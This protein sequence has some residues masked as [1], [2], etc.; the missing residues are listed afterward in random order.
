MVA[1]SNFTFV[2]LCGIL[3][4]VFALQ[5]LQVYWVLYVSLTAFIFFSYYEEK[6]L[7]WMY[8]NLI[9]QKPIDYQAIPRVDHDKKRGM[10]YP[11][12]MP[13]TWYHFVDSSELTVGKVME[14]RAL[15]RTFVLW[16]ATDGTPV[17]QDAYCVHLGA[18]LGVG[19]KVVDNCIECPFH[20]WK[21]NK[22]GTVAEIP[23]NKEP[24]N[25]PTHVKQ[26]TYPCVDWCGWVCVWYHVDDKDPE[27][28]MPEYVPKELKDGDWMPHM[29]WDIGLQT[30][31]CIDW[32]DQVGDHAHFHTLHDEFLIPWT[33]L[34]L[35]A[36][37]LYFFPIA[38]C[39]RLTT[40]MGDDKEWVK[41]V[42]ETGWGAT[43]KHLVFFND[44]AGITW[45]G[46]PIEATMSHTTEMY[47]GP[48][49]IVFHIPFTI[50]IVK[51]FVSNLPVETG[52]IMRVRTWVD[53]RVKHSFIKQCIAWVLT[54]IGA[55]QL[56]CDIQILNNKIRLRK[57]TIQP[58]D[59]PYNRMTAWLKNFM[60]E[61][62]PKNCPSLLEAYKN[63]W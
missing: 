60:S 29:K 13:N 19:G 43:G 14:V 40:F 53:G 46:K 30:L 1:K 41:K 26:R 16:R 34:S 36:W 35:P 18:N 32:I 8:A 2:P 23:Y 10:T 9:M 44:V 11:T 63:D 25:C 52:S 47:I 49:M 54:G 3:A 4:G 7:A 27:Y 39:H 20:N 45:K 58:T 57:P 15:N 62:T 56:M 37:F 28:E 31:N 22:D 48:S 24:H 21:F 50:G 12:T 61:G 33:I 38:I 51:V 17:C 42:Q 5:F 59:G 55:S 6:I